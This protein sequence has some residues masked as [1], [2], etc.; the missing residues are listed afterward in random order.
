M[1]DNVWIETVQ[2]ILA[3]FD[4]FQTVIDYI[5]PVSGVKLT[6]PDFNPSA[7]VPHIT[8]TIL[9][10][11]LPV[12]SSGMLILCIDRYHHTVILSPRIYSST[13]GK[14]VDVSI[15][16]ICNILEIPCSIR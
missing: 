2:R 14:I 13:D 16:S 10:F 6:I 12:G 15:S 8:S 11:D 1:Q 9:Y 4:S 3:K 5:M 7:L